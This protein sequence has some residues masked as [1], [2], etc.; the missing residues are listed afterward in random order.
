MTKTITISRDS[1]KLLDV[2]KMMNLFCTIRGP[3]SITFWHRSMKIYTVWYFPNRDLPLRFSICCFALLFY[4]FVLGY[5]A[6]TLLATGFRR[7]TITICYRI[8]SYQFLR[9][10]DKVNQS[11]SIDNPTSDDSLQICFIAI[12]SLLLELAW[13]NGLK[14]TIAVSRVDDSFLRSKGKVERLCRFMQ[15]IILECVTKLHL[16]N[17]RCFCLGAVIVWKDIARIIEV[18]IEDIIGFFASISSLC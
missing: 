16:S 18:L 7:R 6:F 17:K 4:Y 9:V 5:P 13:G 15:F 12:W 3:R 11:I 8:Y 10:C 2:Q 14:F 1:N